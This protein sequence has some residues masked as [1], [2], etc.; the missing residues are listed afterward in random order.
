VE[1]EFKMQSIFLERTSKECLRAI[2]TVANRIVMEAEAGAGCA[3]IA[4]GI[5]ESFE[6]GPQATCFDCLVCQRPKLVGYERAAVRGIAPAKSCKLHVVKVSH[7][8][9]RITCK[10]CDSNCVA[11]FSVAAA[12][13]DDPDGWPTLTDKYRSLRWTSFTPDLCWDPAPNRVDVGTD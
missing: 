2:E 12:E 8:P 1:G 9:G 10:T 13:S 5:E 4:V 6:C 7:G 3:E 11:G